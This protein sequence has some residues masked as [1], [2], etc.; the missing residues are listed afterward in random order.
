M[1]NT[2]WSLANT[3]GAAPTYI[4]RGVLSPH[5]VVDVGDA[6]GLHRGSTD[7]QEHL[8]PNEQQVHHVGSRPVAAD[9]VGVGPLV[10]ARAVGCADVAALGAPADLARLVLVLV[11]QELGQRRQ[12]RAQ[13]HDDPAAADQAR[14]VPACP[15]VAHEE[16]ERQVPDLEAA[17]DHT[18]VSALQVEPT[19]QG[20]QDAHLRGQEEMS[21]P[22]QEDAQEASP[23]RLAVRSA[24]PPRDPPTW[25]PVPGA[26][27]QLCKCLLT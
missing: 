13:R 11:G 24:H 21:E 16:N 10:A 7:A 3:A 23:S 22:I 1:V 14:P 18:H 20:G 2:P 25:P 4:E 17:S 8:G 19:L 9:E 12:Q 15:E 26:K 6:Q 5:V 27:R